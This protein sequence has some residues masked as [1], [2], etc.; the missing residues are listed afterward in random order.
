MER[1][2]LSLMS[3]L[4]KLED[5]SKTIGE[6]IGVQTGFRALDKI[7]NKM[8]NGNLVVIGSRPEM[9]K[10]S[11]AL[12]V[13]YNVCLDTKRPV[14][15]F[16]T[17]MTSEALTL[18]IL[19]IVAKVESKLIRKKNLNEND[20]KAIAKAVAKILEL[21]LYLDDTCSIDIEHIV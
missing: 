10:T 14:L 5:K 13:A 19:G 16:A 11:L 1:I 12:N 9:G 17:E 2:N 20:I 8:G 6:T 3:I 4:K 15:Y 7:L 18:N 21:P